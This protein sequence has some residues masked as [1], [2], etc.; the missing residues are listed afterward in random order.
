VYLHSGGKHTVQVYGPADHALVG[1]QGFRKYLYFHNLP[2]PPQTALRYGVEYPPHV[3]YSL[4]FPTGAFSHFPTVCLPSLS[5]YEESNLGHFLTKEVLCR[6][7][8]LAGA[9]LYLGYL[10]ATAREALPPCWMYLT[11]P[12]PRC[13]PPDRIELSSLRYKGRAFPLCKGGVAGLRIARRSTAY[14]TVVALPPLSRKPLFYHTLL[15]CVKQLGQPSSSNSKY[16]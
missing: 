4:S 16:L 5:Q 11:N 7:T 3:L 2:Y 15:C 14:E 8:I 1:E 10:P 9:G 13:E 6:L 12:R